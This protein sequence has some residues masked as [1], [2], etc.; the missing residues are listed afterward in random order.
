M[1][2]GALDTNRPE[3]FSIFRKE[4]R[5]TDNSVSLQQHKSARRIGEINFPL[6]EGLG[7]I[8]GNG[9]DI[10][11][12]TELEGLLGAEA[13]SF[14]TQLLPGNCLMQLELTAPIILA[15]EGVEPK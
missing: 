2:E 15:T 10:D 7:N 1:A 8:L 3:P 14:A 9:V 4:S 13:G 6:V 11:L 12:E 5:Q